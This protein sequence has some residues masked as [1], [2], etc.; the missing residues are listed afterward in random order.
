[1]LDENAENLLMRTSHRDQSYVTSGTP[2]KF[3]V[4]MAKVTN[5]N[6][7]KCIKSILVYNN[8][9]IDYLNVMNLMNYMR[10]RFFGFAQISDL[11]Y[12]K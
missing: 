2:W 9:V 4:M 5:S 12:S 7:K 6:V 1:M 11:K 3:R 10:R 8:N